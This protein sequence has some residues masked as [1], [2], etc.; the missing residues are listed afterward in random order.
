MRT[1]KDISIHQRENSEDT[2]KH[3]QENISK[4]ETD[5]QFLLKLM[6]RGERLTGKTVM[7]KYEIHDRRLRDLHIAGKC[8][9]A[10]KLNEKGKRMYVEYYIT[11]PSPPTKK[12]VIEMFSKKLIQQDL[13]DNENK[14]EAK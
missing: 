9:K 2:E 1:I 10:W 14:T 11:P 5:C 6:K 3:L 8:E 12:A 13:F 7:T 4:L